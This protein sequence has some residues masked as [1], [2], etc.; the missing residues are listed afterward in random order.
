VRVGCPEILERL[1]EFV[2][3]ETEGDHVLI[4][5]FGSDFCDFHGGSRSEL[6][7]GVEYEICLWASGR[8]FALLEGIVDGGE[9]FRD[10]LLAQEHYA[11]GQ[12]DFGVNDALLVESGG[13][14]LR[15]LGVV[16]RFAEERRGP[17]KEFQ[18]LRKAAQVIAGLEFIVFQ[19]YRIFFRQGFNAV[20]EEH[21]FE[22][23]V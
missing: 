7:D 12:S 21:A 10:I 22:V 3:A 6:A 15:K 5:K 23:Q 17:F 14:V 11:D 19:K 9:I 2:A 16:V 4:A 13:G 20:W 8:F 1:G 18:E